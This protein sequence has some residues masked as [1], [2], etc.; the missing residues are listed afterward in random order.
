LGFIFP[1]GWF[2]LADETANK[3]GNFAQKPKTLAGLRAGILSGEVKAA[4]LVE[5]YYERIAALNPILNVYL[6]LTRERALAAAGRMDDLAAKGAELP[7]LAG[8]PVAVKDVLAMQGAP[9]TAG[10]K[11]LEN[12]HPPYDATAVARLEDAAAII[13]GKLNCD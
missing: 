6:S 2:D 7:P 5:S 8:V 9:A 10:S 13:L 12:Y 4:S 1:E 3:T 11:I